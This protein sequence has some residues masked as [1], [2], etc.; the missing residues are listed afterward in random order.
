[1]VDTRDTKDRVA[2]L[3]RTATIVGAVLALA[4]LAMTLGLIRGEAAADVRTMTAVGA[5]RRTRRA[6]TATAAA[7]LAI[8]GV[9]L[10]SAGA[11]IAIVAAYRSDLSRLSSPP[12]GNLLLL[13]VG[14]P[15]L[16]AMTGWLLAGRQPPHLAR[17]PG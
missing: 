17:V 2:T 4:I 10:A 7:A 5:P 8:V 13:A 6:V 16:A 12:T 15:I 3:G 9:V 14:L 11:Y 1:V